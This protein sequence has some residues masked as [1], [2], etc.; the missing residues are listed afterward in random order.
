MSITMGYLA[1]QWSSNLYHDGQQSSNQHGTLEDICPYHSAHAALQ[2]Q[3]H[4]Q[5]R[6]T[7]PITVEVYVNLL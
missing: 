5:H 7:I 4:N 1:L 3:E 2:Q 6:C